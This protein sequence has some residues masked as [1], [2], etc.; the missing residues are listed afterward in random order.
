MIVAPYAQPWANN[1][2][3][4]SEEAFWVA[5]KATAQ[6]LRELR[7]P[8]PQIQYLP[9]RFGYPGYVDRQPTVM[10]V[11]GI[12]RQE[13]GF[14]PAGPLSMRKTQNTKPGDG[15]QDTSYEGSDRLTNGGDPLGL[16]GAG[17]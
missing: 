1:Y 11:F 15:F 12:N 6:Q 14:M 17:S 9:P 5:E 2:Q 10:Q 13:P 4:Q 7:P 8:L 16:G 3:R